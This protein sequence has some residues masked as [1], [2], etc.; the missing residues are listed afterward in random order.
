MQYAAVGDNDASTCGVDWDGLFSIS[1][2]GQRHSLR[3]DRGDTALEG[4]G[5]PEVLLRV[6]EFEE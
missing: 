1:I 2:V 4:G 3:L 6:I 5:R